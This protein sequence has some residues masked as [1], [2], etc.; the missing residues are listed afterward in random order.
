MDDIA[1]SAEA[2]NRTKG[3][4]IANRI[5]DSMGPRDLAAVIFPQKNTNAQDL[6]ADRAALRRAVDTYQP[7]PRP[8]GRAISLGVIRKTRHFLHQRLPGHRRSIVYI[9]TG[10]HFTE[11]EFQGSS[12]LEDGAFEGGKGV[13][14][15]FEIPLST[16]APG[17]YLLTFTASSGAKGAEVQRDVRFS[18]E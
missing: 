12:T 5:I 17:D 13:E 10:F 4:E 6:T 3:K 18:V 11:S 1:V 14:H 9:T 7:W 16:L 15:R 8:G 2:Y